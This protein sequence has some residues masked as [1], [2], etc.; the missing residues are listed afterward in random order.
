MANGFPEVLPV[1]VGKFCKP[2]WTKAAPAP[3][4]AVVFMISDGEPLIF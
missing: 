1:F 3:W 4:K 2:V